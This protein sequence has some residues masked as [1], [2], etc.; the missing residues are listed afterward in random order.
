MNESE[1]ALL[2]E[3]ARL[4]DEAARLALAIEKAIAAVEAAVDRQQL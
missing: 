3:L 2:A 4:S 1:Q